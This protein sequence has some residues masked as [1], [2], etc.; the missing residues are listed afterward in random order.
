MIIKKQTGQGSIETLALLTTF[1]LTIK[2]GLMLFWLL[3]GH[4]W[5]DH[6]LYQHLVCRAQGQMEALCTEKLLKESKRFI[7][8]GAVKN[9]K[10]R[11]QNNSWKGSLDWNIRGFSIPIIRTLKLP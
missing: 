1:I 9:I 11:R 8:T 3:A 2:G 6:Q 4:L 7:F 5:M 10:I